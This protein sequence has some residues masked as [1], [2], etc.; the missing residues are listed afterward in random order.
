[1]RLDPVRGRLVRRTFRPAAGRRLPNLDTGTTPALPD[2]PGLAEV[3]PWTSET[4]L[5]LER[6]PETIV[7][8]GGGH[9]G[10]EFASMLAVFGCRVMLV[11]RAGQLLPHE[12]PDVAANVTDVLTDQGVDVWL[13]A[14]GHR[15]AARAGP[16]RRRP[17]PGRRH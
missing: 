10:C 14:G 12:D 11:Q 4:V 8:L 1:M 6:L 17:H 3:D 5:R 7:V 2:V 15:H 16:R 9:V 13:S